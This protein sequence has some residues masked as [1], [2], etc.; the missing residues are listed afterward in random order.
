MSGNRHVCAKREAKVMLK[1]SAEGILRVTF[2]NHQLSTVAVTESN[3]ADGPVLYWCSSPFREQGEPLKAE[4]LP[5]ACEKIP[6]PS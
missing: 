4:C 2:P 5:W 1:S 3:T 6:Y